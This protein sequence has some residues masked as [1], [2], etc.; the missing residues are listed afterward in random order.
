MAIRKVR[1]T[2]LL[3]QTTFFQ[4]QNFKQQNFIKRDRTLTSHLP[5]KFKNL[6]VIFQTLER[7]LELKNV[8]DGQKFD[9]LIII[10][11]E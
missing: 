2:I 7:A 8:P 11:G 9:I 4:Q 5:D 1:E 6:I 3:F 10:L